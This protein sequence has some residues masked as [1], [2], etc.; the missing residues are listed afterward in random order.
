MDTTLQPHHSHKYLGVLYIRLVFLCANCVLVVVA[1]V[2][3]NMISQPVTG[4]VI[5]LKVLLSH[6]LTGSLIGLGGKAIKELI[7]IT[8]AK[9]H[10]SAN[11][12]PYPG[13]S[14]RVVVIHGEL[15][16]VVLAI[17]LVWEMIAL[18]ASAANP[19][20]VEWN[21]RE[22][23]IFLGQNDDVEV[24]GKLTIPA[25]AGGLILGRGG[26]NI[27]TIA[28][29]SQANVTMTSKEDAIF[30]QER[31]ITISGSLGNCIKCTILIIHKL[32]EPTDFTQYANRGTSY[33]SPLSPG[34]AFGPSFASGGYGVFGAAP[35]G[36]MS[37]Q[38]GF[39]R[40]PSASGGPY[41]Q[42][43]SP[44][45]GLY[46]GQQ[47]HHPHPHS[48]PHSHGLLGLGGGGLRGGGSH[49]DVAGGLGL[50][51]EATITFTVPDEL[52]GNIFGRQG[53]TMREII[54]IS[55]ARVTV[56]PR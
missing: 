38:Q 2:S 49:E 6:N 52:V 51:T 14:D 15:D 5:S 25:A 7:E 46:A 26:A 28:E 30:T 18:V 36:T 16:A 43:P 37:S 22:R 24:V 44:D 54:G 45:R 33:A 34:T 48:H 1:F 23:L 8:G 39:R 21:P 31:V 55:R 29:E 10:V 11:T 3:M 13:T 56:S 17:N 4:K 20:E 35:Y 47:A 41:L 42:H 50:P 32:D 40:A 9:I 27:Q 19:K 12:E 53:A